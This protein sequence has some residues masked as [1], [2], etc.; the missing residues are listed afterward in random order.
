MTRLIL[1]LL[2]IKDYEVCQS[3]ETLKLQLQI[4]NEDRE[5]LTNILINIF[6]PKPIEAAPIEYNQIQSSSALFSRR[7]AALETKD[8]E[9][10]RILK[11]STHLGKPDIAPTKNINELEKELGVDESVSQCE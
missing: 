5:R 11:S 10:A 3:C 6:Q 8:R 4:A 7:R 2:G 1:R 9:E